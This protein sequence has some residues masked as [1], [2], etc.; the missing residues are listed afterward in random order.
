MKY[1]LETLT[2]F[3]ALVDKAHEG[4]V[5]KGGKPYTDHLKRVAGIFNVLAANLPEGMMSHEQKLRGTFVAYG[6]DLFEDT[7]VQAANLREL[8]YDEDFIA[9]LDA[10]S[11][12]D[13]KPQYMTWIQ[14]IADGGNLTRIL[15]KMADNRDNRDPDRI[16][17]LPVEQQGISTRYDRAYDIL[18]PAMDKLVEDFMAENR[19]NPPLQ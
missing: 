9:D 5:D 16:A 11:R 1:T 4:Q 18:K 6:H 10:L 3:M 17:Q 15:V 13:P 8:G 12:V 2:Q 7:A 14:G 19:E